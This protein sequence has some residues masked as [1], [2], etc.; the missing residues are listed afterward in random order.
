M[1]T[2]ISTSSIASPPN[3]PNWDFGF[4]NIPSG[5]PDHDRQK[6]AN[7]I[8]Q[9]SALVC[10]GALHKQSILTTHYSGISFK[11]IHLW[12]SLYALSENVD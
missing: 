10:F 11:S 1:A 5:N 7:G 3:Y 4:E 12:N 8:K 6:R 9:L 2:K